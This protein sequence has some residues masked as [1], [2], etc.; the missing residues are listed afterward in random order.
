MTWFLFSAGF[1]LCLLA[2]SVLRFVARSRSTYVKNL[3]SHGVNHVPL[4][5]AQ[6]IITVG[7]GAVFAAG[8]ALIVWGWI[9]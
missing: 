5:P 4:L 8:C 3:R 1:F 9:R 6:V 7:W 2:A